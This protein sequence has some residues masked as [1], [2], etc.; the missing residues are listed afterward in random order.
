MMGN[1]SMV[2]SETG[3]EEDQGEYHFDPSLLDIDGGL[4]REFSKVMDSKKDDPEVIEM[5]RKMAEEKLKV[6]EKA[7]EL[8]DG[9]SEFIKK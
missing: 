5:L 4:F 2:N 7:V 9:E 6:D 8:S 3:E 1:N